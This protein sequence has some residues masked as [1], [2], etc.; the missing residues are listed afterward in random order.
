MFEVKF[1]PHLKS[2]LCLQA[3]VAENYESSQLLPPVEPKLLLDSQPANAHDESQL[4]FTQYQ[5]DPVATPAPAEH[6]KSS[7]HHHGSK[8]REAKLKHSHK[9]ENE[10]KMVTTT[11]TEAPTTSTTTSTTGRKILSELSLEKG[12]PNL[13]P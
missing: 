3:K 7:S 11:H 10:V 9:H 1:S 13:T 5:G 2:C 6:R 12:R 4:Q 8:H